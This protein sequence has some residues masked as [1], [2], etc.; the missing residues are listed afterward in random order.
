MRVTGE[1]LS[2]DG[3]VRV[4]KV[5]GRHGERF[6]SPAV[7]RELI[8]GWARTRGAQVLEIFEELDEPGSRADRPLLEKALRR[9][10]SGISQGIVVSKVS[11]FG[12]SLLDGISAIERVRA[13]G[14]MF[15]SVQN[16]LD[17]STD[18]GRLVMQILLSLA[19]WESERIG[20]DWE[21]AR[22]RA[23]GRGVYV[24]PGAP[25]G[26]RRTRSGRL[27]PDP[28]TADIVA[29]VFRRRADGETM[30]SLARWLEAQRILTAGGNP[31]WTA[32]AM[33]SLLRHRAYLGELRYCRTVNERAHPPLIDAATWQAAQRPKRTVIPQDR[34]ARL[35]AR[36]VRCAGCTM[37]MTATWHGRSSGGWEIIYACARHSASG[38]CPAPASIAAPYLEA[39][40][41]ECF[42]ELLARR[43]AEPATD[44][45]RAGEAV[46]SA[47]V[48]LARYR[49]SDQVLSALGADAYVAGVAA[50]GERVRRARLKLAALRDAHFIY[51]L[52][53]TPELER[54]WV[55][56]ND[57]QRRQL[58]TRVIDCVFV[59]AGHERIEDRVT[60]CR[61]GTAPT[62]P[63]TGTVKARQARRFT[64]QAK[65]RW[66]APKPWPT[67]RIERELTDY[68]HGQRVW[69]TAAQFEAAGRRRLHEQIVR[70]AGIKCWAHHAGLPIIGPPPSR[71]SWTEARIRSALELYLRRKRRWPTHAQFH[72][73]GLA[74]LHRAIRKTGGV[75]RWS[76][77]LSIP[78]SPGQR[79]GHRRIKSTVPEAP[80]YRGAVC[81]QPDAPRP[82][83]ERA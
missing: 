67:E 11:R 13:A 44:L 60:I 10:E 58:L 63:R 68:L 46:K 82:R 71:E 2:V 50:R 40:I 32:S 6:I 24:Q 37:T 22:A 64:P 65:H 53:A 49:D 36:L 9:V 55:E 16:A 26:Y 48:A 41:E 47:S 17:T 57:Q 75:E 73:D 80:D 18:T 38:R 23:V 52:P 74:G 27:R 54:Q 39:Y 29:E 43:R 1:Q 25:V 79:R 69:P 20:A 21:Q 66:P 12:R 70:H 78:L 14:G 76:A 4:S 8:E 19:E 7:Q 62:L 33:Q 42:F 15:V 61:T 31:G 45:A 81:S 34:D 30:A 77:E 5:A 56:M 3:Y 35:L 51:T 72:A 83:A 59:T 28:N